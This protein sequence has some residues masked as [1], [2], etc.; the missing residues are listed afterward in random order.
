MK[1]KD[2]KI[3][4]KLLVFRRAIMDEIKKRSEYPNIGKRGCIKRLDAVLDTDIDINEIVEIDVEK[5]LEASARGYCTKRN[6]EK[7]LDPDLLKDVVQSIV[8]SGCIKWR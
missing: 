4:E 2:T 8:K 1:I 6:E 3:A 7:I 5:A